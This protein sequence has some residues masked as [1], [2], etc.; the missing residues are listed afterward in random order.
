MHWL[1]F[2]GSVLTSF[3][4][5]AVIAIMWLFKNPALGIIALSGAFLSL[6]PVI[7]A[8]IIY[9]IIAAAHGDSS[10]DIFNGTAFN[11]A[12]KGRG[13]IAF[14][15]FAT[16]EIGRFFMCKGILAADTFFRENAQVLYASRFRTLPLGLAAGFGYGFMLTMLNTGNLFLATFKVVDINTPVTLFSDDACPGL[17]VIFWQAL[18]ALFSQCC[19]TAWTGL[20]ML[21]VA[22][23]IAHK[24]AQRE[25]RAMYEITQD[26]GPA[27]TA[28]VPASDGDRK[29]K[30]FKTPKK[31]RDAPVT[32]VMPQRTSIK[33]AEAYMMIAFVVMMH[34][35]FSL[36]ALVNSGATANNA[37]VPGR[38]CA[39]SLPIQAFL[40]VASGC[41]CVYAAK[42]DVVKRG[43][44]A[45][46]ETVN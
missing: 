43:T 14:F 7:V 20:M 39:T 37:S 13:W 6:A 17:P 31:K 38:G 10:P 34:A 23:L 5:V 8:G 29:E 11:A 28:A 44:V 25:S 36:V 18:V 45:P 21:A 3:G 35:I 2:L 33:L 24:K 26:E 32:T 30:K 16:Q 15:T 27:E 4:P 42:R 40:T 46:M 9:L 19:Q 22:G 1:L 12:L 41:A